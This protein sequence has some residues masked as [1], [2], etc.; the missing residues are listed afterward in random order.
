MNASLLSSVM[1]VLAAPWQQRRN[2]RGMWSVA[3]IVALCWL[4]PIALLGWSLFTPPEMA[5]A[6]RHSALAA[7]GAAVAVL[8]LAWWATMLANV[9]EQNHPTLA[10]VV[11]SHPARLRAALLVGWGV[12]LGVASLFVFRVVPEDRVDPLAVSVLVGAVLA[13]LAAS[14]RWPSMWMLGCVA[15]FATHRAMHWSGLDAVMRVVAQ[16]WRDQPLPWAATILAASALLLMALI[17]GGGNR[18][19]ANYTKRRSRIQRF[20][21][22]ARGE[23]PKG[24]DSRG[25]LDVL[26]SGPYHWWLRRLLARP[27]SSAS[28]RLMLGLGPGVHWTTVLAGLVATVVTIPALV[29]LLQLLRAWIPAMVVV[30]PS[31]LSSGGYGAMGALLASAIQAQSRLYQT[32]REQAL[33]AL[34][35]GTPR[36][37]ETGRQLSLWMTGQLAAAAVGGAVAMLALNAMAA[38]IDPDFAGLGVTGMRYM[39]IGALGV[40][41]FQWPRWARL[42]AP[43]SLGTLWP[44]LAGTGAAA[45]AFAGSL[46]DLWTPATFGIVAAVVVLAWCAWRWHR[47]GTEPQA[48]PVGRLA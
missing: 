44:T 3:L 20:Q 25:V 35:P 11:P 15:P 32:R 38:R 12:L 26:S 19:A 4:P 24:G 10:Q 16:Q 40:L 33:L 36:G 39:L 22:R 46:V 42:R 1:P 47:M 8:A 17:Q 34:L 2:Q 7:C 28:G 45:A 5:A 29:G 9:L 31:M 30:V 48:F 13:A 21:A 43:S 14:V 41:V 18:H 37:A 27:G 6:L 23:L